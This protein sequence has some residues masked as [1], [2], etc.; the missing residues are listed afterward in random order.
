[1]GVRAGAGAGLV[2]GEPAPD[3]RRPG[4]L[5]RARP[6]PAMR[7]SNS[8]GLR[9]RARAA[10]LMD[11]PEAK[12]QAVRALQR[13]YG[14]APTCDDA[15]LDLPG[16]DT[17][18]RPARPDL[19]HP[20][21][22]PRR[23]PATVAGRAALLHAIA[24]IEFNAIN[25]ALDAL[26]RFSGLPA[27]FYSDWLEVAAEE[28]EHYTLLARH[29]GTLGFGYGDFPAHNGLWEMAS[30]TAHDPLARMALV[31]RMLEARGLD[32][33]P[34][35]RARLAQAGDEPGAAILDIILRD[36]IGHVAIGNRWFAW[37]C[38]RRGL[39]VEDAFARL[40]ADYGV[41]APHPP[42]NEAARLAAGFGA[43]ELEGW[44]TRQR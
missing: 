26:A 17:P 21:A 1:M 7:D 4:A 23:R 10:L 27:P 28:A 36:E 32:V 31:P 30:R 16:V 11:S 3:A 14:A 34:G 15:L 38:D 9:A 29:L 12:V 22:L 41:E 44:A 18:G 20:R 42:L 39:N 2:A 6:R 37:F 8:P 43:A 19:V 35:I 40:L 25:L 33:T 5:S 24:H 13:E